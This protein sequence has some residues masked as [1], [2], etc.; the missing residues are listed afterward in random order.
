[1]QLVTIPTGTSWHFK[2]KKVLLIYIP[3]IVCIPSGEG[4]AG[5]SMTHAVSA[6]GGGEGGNVRKMEVNTPK[7]I[8]IFCSVTYVRSSSWLCAAGGYFLP[9]N[10]LFCK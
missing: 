9:V 8:S 7:E 3:E 5:N 2:L 10:V 6:F 1:V 4:E